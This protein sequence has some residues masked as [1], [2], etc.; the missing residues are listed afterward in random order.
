MDKLHIDEFITYLSN[1]LN[2]KF[3][4]NECSKDKILFYINLNE[5]LSINKI[6]IIQFEVDFQN[7][8]IDKIILNAY[9]GSYS[10]A[11]LGISYIR[12]NYRLASFFPKEESR[13]EIIDKEKIFN[14]IF[15]Y[16]IKIN[17]DNIKMF[18]ELSLRKLIYE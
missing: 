1:F 6:H 16:I 4:K 3:Y 17:P 2:I 5:S 10:E 12:E 14:E 11:S 15:D 8:L 9:A 18:R 7:K 13:F